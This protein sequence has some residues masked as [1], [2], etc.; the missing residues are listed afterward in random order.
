M[1]EGKIMREVEEAKKAFDAINERKHVEG[2]GSRKNRKSRKSRK[3]RKSR[4]TKRNKRR[5]NR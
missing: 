3:L 4:K 1:E 5:K 2:G